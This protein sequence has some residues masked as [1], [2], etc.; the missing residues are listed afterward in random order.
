MYH[1][2]RERPRGVVHI[3][4]SGREKRDDIFQPS[5]P[6]TNSSPVPLREVGPMFYITAEF[7]GKEK[8]NILILKNMIICSFELI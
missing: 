6:R 5:S 2:G 7:C 1:D 4:A 8:S 3:T